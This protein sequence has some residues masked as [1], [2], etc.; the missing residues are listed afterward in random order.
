VTTWFAAITAADR[1]SPLLAATTRSTVEGPLRWLAPTVV[2]HETGE[3]TDQTH[4]ASVFTTSRTV[5]PSAPISAVVG[6]TTKLQAAA[7]C[8]IRSA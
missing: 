6:V 4:P 2:T 3:V 7:S 8:W 5:P 1:S